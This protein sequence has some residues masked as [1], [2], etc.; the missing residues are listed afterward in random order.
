MREASVILNKKNLSIYGPNTQ[1]AILT[2]QDILEWTQRRSA[3]GAPKLREIVFEH[4]GGFSPKVKLLF[5]K[6]RKLGGAEN[7]VQKMCTAEVDD[8]DGLDSDDYE[9]WDEDDD[10]GVCNACLEF[11]C[12]GECEIDI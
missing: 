12:E 6:L 1:A 2:F 9:D 3:L 7:V 10:Q 5:E 4:C 11:P 8:L